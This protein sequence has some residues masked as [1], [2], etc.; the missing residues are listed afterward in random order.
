MD[1]EEY[2]VTGLSRISQTGNKKV[3]TS[4]QN[5]GKESFSICEA[6]IVGVP[7]GSIVVLNLYK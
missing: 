7:Q 3:P 5:L 6:V 4:T 2:G 1:L